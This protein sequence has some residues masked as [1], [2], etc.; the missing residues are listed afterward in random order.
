VVRR[1]DQRR[2]PRGIFDFNLGVLRWTW[3][4]SY[5]GYRALGTDRYP[6]FSLDEERDYPAT[7]GVAY[8][9][10]E[11]RLTADGWCSPSRTC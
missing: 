3:R 1:G 2:Y 9:G 10:V 7:L 11:S 6:P 4:V 5:Y 8:P